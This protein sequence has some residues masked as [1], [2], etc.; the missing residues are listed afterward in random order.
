MLEFV[1]TEWVQCAY[2]PPWEAPAGE[3][4]EDEEYAGEDDESGEAWSCPDTRPALWGDDVGR[5]G[6]EEYV[7]EYDEESDDEYDEDEE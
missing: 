4:Y 3:E 6:E 2:N 7:R 5:E 1:S